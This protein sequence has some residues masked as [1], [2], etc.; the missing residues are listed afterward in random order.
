VAFIGSIVTAIH[1]AWL[2]IPPGVRVALSFSVAALVAAALGLLQAF[3]WVIPSSM[4][5]AK[6]E[7]IAFLTY[8]LP[9]LAVLATQLVRS[10]IAPAI[11]AWFLSTF[12]YAQAVKVQTPSMGGLKRL[13]IWVRC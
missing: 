13:D 1:N 8:A 7:V 3:N 10:K 12:G 6:G 2:S 5:D 9:V 11:V 4:V